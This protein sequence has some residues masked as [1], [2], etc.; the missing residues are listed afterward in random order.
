MVLLDVY[1]KVVSEE[2]FFRYPILEN[3]NLVGSFI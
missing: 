2:L 1:L 3:K